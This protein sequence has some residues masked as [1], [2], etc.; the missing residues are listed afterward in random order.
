M[1]SFCWGLAQAAPAGLYSC[2]LLSF[3]H[4]TMNERLGSQVSVLHIEGSNIAKW[5]QK[6]KTLANI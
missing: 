5:K 1:V 6:L 4:H 3:N 2:R